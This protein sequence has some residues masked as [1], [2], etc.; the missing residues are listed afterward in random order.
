MSE[1]EAINRWL[2]EQVAALDARYP[3]RPPEPVPTPAEKRRRWRAFQREAAARAVR[4][5]GLRAMGV[6]TRWARR[7]AIG[8]FS[9]PDEVRRATDGA[10]RRCPQLG[11]KTV[12]AIRQRYPFTPRPLP[13]WAAEEEPPYPV[14]TST[15]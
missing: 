11:V 3:P 4:L 9:T 14:R 7:P 6:P 13:D 12:A 2:R 15:V 10:L 8:G 5:H 1:N